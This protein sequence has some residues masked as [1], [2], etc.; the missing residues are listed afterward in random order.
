MPRPRRL[1]AAL[2]GCALVAAPGVATATPATAATTS[3]ALV[4]D[5]QSELG[6]SDDWQPDCAATELTRVATAPQFRATFDVPGGE[7][8]LQGRARTTPGTSTTERV[9]R[10]NGGN[11]PLLLAGPAKVTFSYDDTSHLVTFT[12]GGRRGHHRRRRVPGPG[13]AALLADPRAVL[14]RHGRPVRER[15]RPP[16]TGAGSPAG[17]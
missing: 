14:L 16:T 15:H 5:L 3:V 2:L 10:F 7:L 6:C 4:G 9:A 11:I 13:L 8:E 17:R 12:P 1:Y